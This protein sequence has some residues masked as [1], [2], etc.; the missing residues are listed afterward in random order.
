[1]FAPVVQVYFGENV[2]H[3]AIV[4]RNATM[5]AWLLEDEHLQDYRQVLLQATATGDF[6]KM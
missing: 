5:A 3:I 6:F 1:M 2:L 4:K